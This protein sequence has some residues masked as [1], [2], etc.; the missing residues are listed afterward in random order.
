MPWRSESASL[1]VE[2]SKA[3]RLATKEAIAFG[4]EQSMRIFPSVSRVMK[5][6]VGSTTGLTTVRFASRF[7]AMY[8][9]YCTEAPPIGSAPMRRPDWAIRSM[10]MTWESSWQYGVR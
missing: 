10:L 7:S 1:P 5:Y 8:C 4:D 6:Q 9:Q 3:V 2:M